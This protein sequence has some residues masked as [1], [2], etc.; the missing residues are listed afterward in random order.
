MVNDGEHEKIMGLILE[1][2]L[3]DVARPMTAA[4][5][6]C[7]C[8]AET[9]DGTT[10]FVELTTCQTLT[11]GDSW[12]DDRVLATEERGGEIVLHDVRLGDL[13]NLRPEMIK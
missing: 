1:E 2:T 10:V 5:R 8:V 6:P 3:A 9:L 11:A 4:Q 13:M 7:Y 12:Q